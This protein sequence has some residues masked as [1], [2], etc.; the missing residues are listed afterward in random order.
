MNAYKSDIVLGQR[1]RDRIT[2]L[3]GVAT[4]VHF[5]MNACEQVILTYA[6]D[7]EVKTLSA[8]A[9]DLNHV[10]EA[11]PTIT[12]GRPQG[13]DQAGRAGARSAVTSMTP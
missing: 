11:D 10:P 7:G 9:V 6:H 12:V 1:Y 13:R 3:E 8:D 5:Y 2:G 4:S